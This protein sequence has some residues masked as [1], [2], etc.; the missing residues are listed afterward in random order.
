MS[1][2]KKLRQHVFVDPKL[3]GELIG[4]IIL[5]WLVCLFSMALLLLAWRI[6][7]SPGGSILTH[8]NEMWPY[9]WPA[10]A[11]SFVLLPLAIIDIMRF[12]NRFA[13]P[14]LRL[15]RSMRALARGEHI[16]PIE[17][18]SGDFWH[19]VADEFNAIRLR[20]QLSTPATNAAQQEEH[21]EESP[22]GV[23]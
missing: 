3:Q 10:L 9:C 4:R 2:S 23:N 19:E 15:R 5:Y 22:V 14:L 6:I 1:G 8:A 20:V 11:T 17:F 12:S 7:T 13:G 18:R 21:E 16:D